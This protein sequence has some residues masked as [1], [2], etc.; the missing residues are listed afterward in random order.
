MNAVKSAKRDFVYSN[1]QMGYLPARKFAAGLNRTLPPNILHNTLLARA[2]GDKEAKELL[3]RRH[4]AWDKELV[5]HPEPGGTFAKG[6][7]IVDSATEWTIPG[8]YVPNEAT[9]RERVGLL[10]VP[11]HIEE[12]R[13]AI[14]YPKGDPVILNGFIQESGCCGKVDETTGMPSA[15]EDR[16]TPPPGVDYLAVMWLHRTAAVGVRAIARAL[17]AIIE[18]KAVGEKEEDLTQHI[19]CSLRPEVLLWA[20]AVEETSL[21]KENKEK[22]QG[23]PMP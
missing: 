9:G 17:K 4:P 13:K 20:W 21:G 12:G 7:D 14:I 3:A 11:Q 8:T 16:E 6:E 15:Q 19:Y 23:P 10:V 18:D 2:R 1:E 22:N 5:V